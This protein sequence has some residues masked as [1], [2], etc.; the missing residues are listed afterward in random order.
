MEYNSHVWGS[1]RSI[2]KLLDRVQDSANVLINDNR[3]SNSIDSWDHRRNVAR[4]SLFYRYYNGRCIREIRG[5]VP[6]NHIF[7]R[8]IR[9]SRRAHP[10]MIDYKTAQCIT[11]KTHFHFHSF[12]IHF[13]FHSHFFLRLRY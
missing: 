4:V 5:L 3:V 9:I 7:L 11:G 6:D 10:F 2:L 13:S 1:S 12:F 8:S